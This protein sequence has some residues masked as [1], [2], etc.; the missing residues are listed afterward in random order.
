MAESYWEQAARG[1]V[2]NAGMTSYTNPLAYSSPT[3]TFNS[4]NY[5]A[6]QTQAR[7]VAKPAK[8]TDPTSIAQDLRNQYKAA[9]DT[10]RSDNLARYNQ[11]L[12]MFDDLY[13]RSFGYTDPRN[14]AK[15]PGY[16]DKYGE[17]QKA[18]INQSVKQNAATT[19]AAATDR[20]IYN[21]S[22]ALNQLGSANMEGQRALAD[23]EA[24]RAEG[25][26]NTDSALTQA[27]LGFIERRNDTYPDMNQ[28]IGLEKSVGSG[29]LEGLGGGF[30]GYGGGGGG[31]VGGF[32]GI[33]GSGYAAPEM[34]MYSPGA[35]PTTDPNSQ[36]NKMRQ[37]SYEAQRRGFKSVQEMMAA[38]QT[39][40]A[41]AVAPK[42]APKR[43]PSRNPYQVPSK[44]KLPTPPLQY[45]V[46]EYGSAGR[47]WL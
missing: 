11:G 5:S 34:G 47:Q 19:Q 35:A 37:L 8:A 23:V 41:N 39:G 20:G 40:G 15:I 32:P 1:A 25:K 10:A 6:P 17:D 22:T 9:Y 14:N 12:G 26:L 18:A 33:G 29:S 2:P 43:A 46:P 28:L 7:P 44:M 4:A 24:K 3:T 31:A 21:T 38:M 30:G 45:D 36:G 13:K 27:K 16:W 42:Q